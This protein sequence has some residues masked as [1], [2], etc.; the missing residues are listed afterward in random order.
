MAAGALY[1]KHKQNKLRPIATIPDRS[2]DTLSLT[3]TQEIIKLSSNRQ[4]VSRNICLASRKA[5][6]EDFSQV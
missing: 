4:W 6:E 2:I 3:I 1:E 5:H